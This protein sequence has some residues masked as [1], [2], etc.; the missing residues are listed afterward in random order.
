MNEIQEISDEDREDLFTASVSN[1]VRGH[2]LPRGHSKGTYHNPKTGQEFYNLPSDTFSREH[3][4]KRHR[5]Q[6]D[7][8]ELKGEE[9]IKAAF[10][11]QL[12]Y[13]PAPAELK[14]EWDAREP[15]VEAGTAGK[16]AQAAENQELRDMVKALAEQ[17]ASLKD[18]IKQTRDDPYGIIEVEE[19]PK[20]N[21]IWDF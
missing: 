14:K 12:V 9:R 3:Y 5:L 20:D 19:D 10:G 18:D 16:T 17:V 2:L 6:H 8:S 21:N 1:T 11:V 15:E 7:Y 4:E 13:G